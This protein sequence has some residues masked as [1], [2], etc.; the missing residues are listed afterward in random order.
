[1]GEPRITFALPILL[2]VY[3]ALQAQP[4]LASSVSASKLQKTNAEVVTK[5]SAVARDSKWKL[6]LLALQL[7]WD[8]QILQMESLLVRI[9]KI[10]IHFSNAMPSIFSRLQE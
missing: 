10:D 5:V 6:I 7:E 3:L 4:I 9:S 1:M 2:T 8:A